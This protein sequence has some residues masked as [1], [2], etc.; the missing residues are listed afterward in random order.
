MIISKNL[1]NIVVL[2]GAGISAESGIDTFRDQNGLWENHDIM[3]VASPQGFER[4]AQL[5]Y[6]FY[7][8]RRKQLLS[9]TVAPNAAHIALK[10]LE[11]NFDGEFSI[12]TQNVDDLHERCG[13]KSVI[14]M[15]GELLK[16]RCVKTKEVFTT[17]SNFDEFTNCP[18]C[19]ESGNLRPH[20]V[21]FGEIPFQLGKIEQLLSQC[22]LF[23]SIGTSGSVYPA[24][25]FVQLAKSNKN[26]LT[27]EQNLSETQV[28]ENFDTLIHGS[29]SIEIPKL[30]EEILK[31]NNS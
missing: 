10:K 6:E 11:D 13:T 16:M 3:D 26:C 21:W 8:Q 23:I 30:V 19:L 14:H 1:K 9:D 7:N 5:V 22:D 27:I 28:S 18:C 15:H 20:I 29:S 17:K 25:M 4:N 31:N 2:T 24:A 12:I